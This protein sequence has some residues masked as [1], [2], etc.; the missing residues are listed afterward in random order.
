MDPVAAELVGIGIVIQR[1]QAFALTGTQVKQL[2]M[3]V[4]VAACCSVVRMSVILRLW[5]RYW[6]KAVVQIIKS[7][8]QC[9]DRL[10]VGFTRIG[11]GGPWLFVIMA[12]A[13]VSVRVSV[14][15]VRVSVILM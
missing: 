11:N 2:V 1:D 7:Q 3:S 6:R 10:S 12:T 14:I 9:C 13:S 8:E 5:R 4:A 15:F